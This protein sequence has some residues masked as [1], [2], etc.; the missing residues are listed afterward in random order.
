VRQ[1]W[2]SIASLPVDAKRCWCCQTVGRWQCGITR[3][4]LTDYFHIIAKGV[5]PISTRANELRTHHDRPR[6]TWSLRG[7]FQRLRVVHGEVSPTRLLLPQLH[8]ALAL[9]HET[10]AKDEPLPLLSTWPG[11]LELASRNTARPRRRDAP[12]PSSPTHIPIVC[13]LSR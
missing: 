7:V 8:D 2:R 12:A 1:F 5:K 13:R 3:T 6:D 4:N 9:D 10:A 11:R